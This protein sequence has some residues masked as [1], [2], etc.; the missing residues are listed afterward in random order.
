MIIKSYK[1]SN[2]AC[3]LVRHLAN[4][5]QSCKVRTPHSYQQSAYIN[6]KINDYAIQ[7]VESIKYLGL[8]CTIS[9][10][11]S[12]LPHI[13]K[14]SDKVNSV[15]AFFRR[16]LAHC[17]R[18]L[19]VKCYQIYIRPIIEYAA[20]MWSPYTHSSIHAVEMLQRKA[21]RFACNDFG[22]LSSITGMP[23]HL[24]WDT[25]EQR[26]NQLTLLMLYK[27]INKLVE[28][29][30]HHILTKASASTK[31]STS[32]YTHLHTRIDSYKFSFFPRP[33][34]L[35]NSL[36]NHITQTASYDSFKDLITS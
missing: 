32:K 5:T 10:N 6:Y 19:K 34:R 4:A 24:G 15:Q 20:I 21:A 1:Q 36:P 31:N 7:K 25:L 18:N 8:T 14:I 9:H 17:S 30:H 29:P 23:E 11:L 12:W 22:R 3:R 33:T 16:N 35:W 2:Q 13:S 27:I 26:H 28:V